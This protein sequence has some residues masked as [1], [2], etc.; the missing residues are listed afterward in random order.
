MK[1][2]SLPFTIKCPVCEPSFDHEQDLL[3][4]MCEKHNSE[5]EESFDSEGF[6]IKLRE[7]LKKGDDEYSHLRPKTGR[8]K[9]LI[10]Y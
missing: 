8:S 7:A 3:R 1:Q 6:R 10:N 2:L 9:K 4:S 5:Y